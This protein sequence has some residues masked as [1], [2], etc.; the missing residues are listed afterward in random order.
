MT[1]TIVSLD[2]S[3]DNLSTALANRSYV[4]NPYPVYKML[5]ENPGWQSPSGYRVFSRYAD[6]Q[7]IL[8]SADVF[9]QEGVPYPNFHVLDPPDHTRLRK[10]VAR[11]FTQHAINRQREY[12]AMAVD[13]LIDTLAP[14][15]EMD[16]ITDFGLVLPAQVTAR[17]LGVPLEDAARWHS[18]LWDIGGFRGKVWYVNESTQEDRDRA[19]HAA[20]DAA[21]YFRE[22]IGERQATRGN[23]I[24]SGLLDAREDDDRLTEDEILF[25]L[26]LILGAGLH[27]TASQIGNMMRAILERPGTFDEIVADPALVEGAADESLRYDG[28]LQAEYRVCK[29]D[30]TLGGAEIP[31]GSPVIVVVAAANRDPDV[32][33]DPDK[34]DIR[35]VNAGQHLTFGSGI[36]RCLGAPLA[37]LELVAT[38]RGLSARLPSMQLAGAPVQHDLDRWRGLSKLLVRWS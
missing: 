24:V 30:T 7:Q 29:A 3:S 14:R 38:L 2:N 32:F 33:P 18:W 37:R 27:T 22:L 36:H 19:G 25:S 13:E 26:V 1:S 16:L 5:L 21:N 10:L 20:A 34:F 17:M 4:E 23:D 31:A 15:R 6:V 9:G 12:V 35:R 8:R 28:T 11:P